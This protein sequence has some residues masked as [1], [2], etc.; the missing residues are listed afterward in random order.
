MDDNIFTTYTIKY[1]FAKRIDDYF[2]MYG[3]ETDELKV[4]NINNR[5]NWNYIK[6][7]GANIIGDVP[8]T[9]LQE[10]RNMFDSGVTLWHTTTY[11]LDYSQNNN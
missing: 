8:E 9:D 3:Y 2:S 6:T 5:S 4:P 10:I 11:F 1:Q 7:A